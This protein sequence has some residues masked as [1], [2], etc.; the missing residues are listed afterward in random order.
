[1]M[2]AIASVEVD[3]AARVLRLRSSCGA[4]SEVALPDGLDFV[5]LPEQIAPEW[6]V[7]RELPA[8]ANGIL[9]VALQALHAAV[10]GLGEDALLGG[11]ASSP[12]VLAT[13]AAAPSDPFAACRDP[14]TTLIVADAA[15]DGLRD[16]AA[17]ARVMDVT[18]AMRPLADTAVERARATALAGALGA[19]VVG[20][21]AAPALTAGRAPL[22]LRE[23]V[24]HRIA[25]PLRDLYVSSMYITDRQARTLV[26]FRC[27]DG[28]TGWGETHGTPDAVARVSAMAKDWLGADLLRDRARL[29]RKFARIGFENRHGRTGI[30]AL[31]ALD[32]AAWDASA[33][34]L[35]LPLRVL[36]GDGGAARPVPIACP[37]PA[38]LPGAMVTRAELAA[39]MADAG[40]VSRVAALAADMRARWGARAFKYKSAG[41]GAAWD[42]AA[43]ESLRATLG[44]DAKLRCDPNAAYS[45][46]EALRL[47]RA[48]EDLRL[49][50]HEDP[51]DGLEGMARIG[52]QIATPLATNMC[53]IAPEH[54]AAAYRRGLKITV[55]GDLSYWG[56]VIG[57]RDMAAA[58]RALGLTPSLHSFYESG[59]VTAAN[60]HMALAFGL[61]APHPMD[62]GWP[63]LAEDV[64]APDGFR[65]EAGHIHAPDGVG[66]GITPDPARLAAL[67]SG[68]PIVIR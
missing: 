54:L 59:I 27:A 37:L 47:C 20:K 35:G 10:L 44:P 7:W 19:A 50:F 55:L 65:V 31:A 13:D 51:T 1:M 64:V 39:H 33:R 23:V 24:L 8:G 52:A 60:I 4:V 21:V 18:L 2:A 42:I 38:A 58:A 53:V 3:A 30:A 6:D 46:E 28:T 5:A 32:L 16:L 34:H 40:N 12:P 9:R 62:C 66:L 45:T 14:G 22:A 29:R 61:D 57:I 68:E 63:L 56:S 25:L 11:A 17:L 67:A 15:T 43:L 49:E 36:L 41:T 48:T 26:E